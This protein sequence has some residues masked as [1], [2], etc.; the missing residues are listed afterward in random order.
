LEARKVRGVRKWQPRVVEY[1]R[2]SREFSRWL[3][4]RREVGYNFAANRKDYD[5]YECLPAWA[6]ETLKKHAMDER[7]VIYDSYEFEAAKTH[8]ALWN[9]ARTQLVHEGKIHN[10]SA[11]AM[12]KDDSRVVVHAAGSRQDHDSLE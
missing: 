5:Q 10:L 2:R 4:T 12:G 7:E 9:A 1:E 11:D 8:D 3:I 6:Q